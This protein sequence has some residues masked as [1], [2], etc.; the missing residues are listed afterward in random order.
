[1]KYFEEAKKIWETYVP[2][3]GQADTVQG[4]LMRSIEKLR[5]EAQRNGNINWDDGHVILTDFLTDT[6]INSDAFSEIVKEEIRNDITRIRNYKD[7]YTED[8]LYDR[9]VD[10]I[11]EWCRRNESPIPRPHNPKLHR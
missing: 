5:D 8:D 2:K 9:V 6:F 4:E 7:P 1:M 10:H 3:S 11:V